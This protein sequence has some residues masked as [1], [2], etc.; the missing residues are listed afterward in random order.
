MIVAMLDVQYRASSQ[1]VTSVT[2][3]LTNSGRE[4]STKNSINEM[5]VSTS[6]KMPRKRPRC[7]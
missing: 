4:I 7:A 2:A 6:A 5:M 3:K 1:I